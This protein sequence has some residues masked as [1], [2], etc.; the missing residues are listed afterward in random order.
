MTFTSFFYVCLSFLRLDDQT[1]LPFGPD[2]CLHYCISLLGRYLPI[3]F[4][5]PPLALAFDVCL[6]GFM[7]IAAA[8]A[9][10]VLG[11]TLTV[12]TSELLLVLNA[13][14]F[15]LKPYI[16]GWLYKYFIFTS[17][18]TDN[19]NI[20]RLVFCHNLCKFTRNFWLF[21]CKFLKDV[22]EIRS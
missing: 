22:E 16:S 14:W 10:L 9:D 1:R 12:A 8:P 18:Y 19:I 17:L 20:F 13:G 21:C 11:L 4:S 6:P 2:Y 7:L 3:I 5:S 15:S